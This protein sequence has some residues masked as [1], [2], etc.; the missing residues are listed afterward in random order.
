MSPMRLPEIRAWIRSAASRSC[1]A[2][3]M[4]RRPRRHRRSQHVAGEIIHRRVDAT[5][6]DRHAGRRQAK[7]DAGERADQLGLVDVS[8]VTDAEDPTQN[9]AEAGAECDVETFED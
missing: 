6:L 7:L 1:V 5:A 4:R 8:E 3:M 9:L 2:S